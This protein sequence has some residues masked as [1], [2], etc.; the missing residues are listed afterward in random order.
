VR[1]DFEVSGVAGAEVFTFDPPVSLDF[2]PVYYEADSWNLGEVCTG[3]IKA[4]KSGC[5]N[6]TAACSSEIAVIGRDN[7]EPIRNASFVCESNIC[8]LNRGEGGTHVREPRRPSPQLLPS[9]AAELS[10]AE[11]LS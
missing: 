11:L 6:G 10:E 4:L 9:M 5:V 1:Y 7:Q 8:P 3:L 2:S